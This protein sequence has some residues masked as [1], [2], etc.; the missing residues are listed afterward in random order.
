MIEK[1]IYVKPEIEIIEFEI[2]DSIATSL[3]GSTYYE[4][5]WG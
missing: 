4:E 5:I 3:N 1:D 2:E